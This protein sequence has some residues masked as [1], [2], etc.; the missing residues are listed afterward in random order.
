LDK[1]AGPATALPCSER[2]SCRVLVGCSPPLWALSCGPNGLTA[3][4]MTG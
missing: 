4:G 1:K 2:I 3:T